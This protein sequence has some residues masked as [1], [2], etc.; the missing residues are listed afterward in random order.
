MSIV[1]DFIKCRDFLLMSDEEFFYKMSF[2]HEFTKE[3]VEELEGIN[4]N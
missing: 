4:Q 3:L 2:D 1:L